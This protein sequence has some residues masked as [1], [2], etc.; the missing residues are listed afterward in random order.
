MSDEMTPEDILQ[1]MEAQKR[2]LHPE[3]NLEQL[4]MKMLLN[5]TRLKTTRS[6]LM[7]V[8]SD[9]VISETREGTVLNPAGF[10]EELSENRLVMLDDG[11]SMSG[12]VRCQTCNG[13]VKE[14]NLRRCAC[15]KTCC[16]RQGCGQG[17]DGSMETLY[18]SGWHA[19]YGWL[20]FSLR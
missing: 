1:F 12:V 3:E 15:G 17:G 13:I 6:V 7:D 19:F 10:I 5:P 16:V 14:Q 9:G 20:G 11:T 18:C 4:L 2:Q 8:T